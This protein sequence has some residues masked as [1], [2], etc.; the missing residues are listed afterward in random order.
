MKNRG[1]D[2]AGHPDSNTD[3]WVFLKWMSDMQRRI[4]NNLLSSDAGY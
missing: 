4:D 3:N 1:K 2:K